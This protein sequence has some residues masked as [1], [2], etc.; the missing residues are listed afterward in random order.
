MKEKQNRKQ[1][2][3]IILLVVII[4]IL[5]TPALLIG[6]IVSNSQRQMEKYPI[7]SATPRPAVSAR[8]V[9]DMIDGSCY[10][11][12]GDNYSTELDEDQ[13]R[14]LVDVWIQYLD[15]E[16]IERTKSGEDEEYRTVWNSMARDLTSSADTMQRAFTDNGIDYITVVLS[17]CN[18]EDH[19]VKY[20]TIANGI[21]GY[22][23]VNGIDM[24]AGS[25]A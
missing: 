6:T 11:I 9:A 14:F 7:P 12:Y 1:N 21:A 4:L 17:L 3:I 24:R 20:L 22:D 16:A 15:D 10:Q 19:S 25:A 23:V 18:P 5:L 2:I 8:D 13:E